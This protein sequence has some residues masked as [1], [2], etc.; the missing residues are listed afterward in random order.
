MAEL[1]NSIILKVRLLFVVL[2]N[3]L[4]WAQSGGARQESKS[5]EKSKHRWLALFTPSKVQA[6]HGMIKARSFH[7]L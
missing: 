2:Q 6:R 7:Q 3:H 1:G 4:C 5:P